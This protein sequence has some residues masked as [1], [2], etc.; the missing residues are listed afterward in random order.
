MD[1]PYSTTQTRT[2]GFNPLE[3]TVALEIC[4]DNKDEIAVEVSREE[5]LQ[6]LNIFKGANSSRVFSV[7]YAGMIYVIAVNKINYIKAV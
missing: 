5:Y 2:I 1:E 6:I 4:M 7:N 3:H